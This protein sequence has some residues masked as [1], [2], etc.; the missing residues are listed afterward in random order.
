MSIFP[1]PLITLFYFLFTF[2]LAYRRWKKY[3]TVQIRMPKHF[4]F[5]AIYIFLAGISYVI[6]LFILFWIAIFA[7]QDYTKNEFDAN[8]WKKEPGSRVLMI[9]DLMEKRMLDKKSKGEIIN[10]LGTPESNDTTNDEFLK[11]L[12]C[13]DSLSHNT[14]VI[15]RLGARSGVLQPIRFLEIWFKN[16][17]VLKYEE[18]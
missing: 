12:Y 13:S 8:K 9:D 16:D 6:L 10:L 7:S 5:W 2:W 15:Y 17:T 11:D 3:K 14:D 4:L 1:I 18:R